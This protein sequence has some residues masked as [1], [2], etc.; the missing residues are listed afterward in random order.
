[1]VS[2]ADTDQ[3]LTFIPSVLPTTLDFFQMLLFT[4]TT[5]PAPSKHYVWKDHSCGHSA[6]QECSFSDCLYQFWME[7][8]ALSLQR[9]PSSRWFMMPRKLY[10]KKKKK[11]ECWILLGETKF[12]VDLCQGRWGL[13]VQY[14]W[15]TQDIIS[16]VRNLLQSSSYFHFCLLFGDIIV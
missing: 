8:S 11:K 3:E 10:G 6:L 16:V 13:R 4:I 7:I 9:T 2:K 12:S 5:G 1:M 14:S 15:C